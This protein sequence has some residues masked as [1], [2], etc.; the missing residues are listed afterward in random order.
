[1]GDR[2]DKI[3]ASS[4]KF[5]AFV[6]KQ[7]NALQLR[8]LQEYE[9][10]HGSQHY[11][12]EDYKMRQRT[13]FEAIPARMPCHDCPPPLWKGKVVSMAWIH[14]TVNIYKKGSKRVTQYMLN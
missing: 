3:S 8:S 4:A 13:Y 2:R 1:M 7:L 6:E 9:A 10:Y 5:D 12:Y 14:V 11:Y